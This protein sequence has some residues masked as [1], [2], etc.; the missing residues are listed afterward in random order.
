MYVSWV[1]LHRLLGSP[2][3]HTSETKHRRRE[4]LRWTCGCR[5]TL[6]TLRFYDVTPC[7]A[8]ADAAR[9]ASLVVIAAR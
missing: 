1:A 6:E 5:A 4:L 2:T 3:V 7:A 8:H 9:V